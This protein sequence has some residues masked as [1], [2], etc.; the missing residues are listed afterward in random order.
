MFFAPTP[1]VRPGGFY[2]I[3]ARCEEGAGAGEVVLLHIYG[4]DL[5]VREGLREEP[6]VLPEARPGVENP[7]R[8][9]A[10]R[11]KQCP[12]ATA[13]VPRAQKDEV[14]RA[15]ECFRASGRTPGDGAESILDG[16]V[17]HVEQASERPRR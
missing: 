3:P 2:I 16:V 12:Q 17:V 8:P 14:E 15:V 1:V 13:H 11:A 10:E 4:R 7:D 6:S 5:D 9:H